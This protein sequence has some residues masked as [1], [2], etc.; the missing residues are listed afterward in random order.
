MWRRGEVLDIILSPI[1]IHFYYHVCFF[2]HVPL[3][4]NIDPLGCL[5][6]HLHDLFV[7]C[8]SR[9]PGTLV[10]S[11]LLKLYYQVLVFVAYVVML[12]YYL[13]YVLYILV[14]HV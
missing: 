1:F 4:D 13:P 3:Y 10:T 12:L 9:K 7:V 8:S 11:I 6:L 14:I 5:K 2:E